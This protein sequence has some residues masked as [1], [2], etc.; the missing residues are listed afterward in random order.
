MAQSARSKT[1]ALD[2]APPGL[3]RDSI[4]YWRSPAQPASVQAPAGGIALIPATMA[5]IVGR[6][7]RS[8]SFSAS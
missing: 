3:A 2:S 5:A 7:G 6:A 1:S 8:A 4:G